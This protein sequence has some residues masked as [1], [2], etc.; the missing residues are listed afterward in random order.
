VS[1]PHATAAR[2]GGEG[3][4]PAATAGWQVR[5][6]VVALDASPASAAAARNA[7]R[8]AARLA[9]ELHGLFVEDAAILRLSGLPL[10]VEVGTFSAMPRRLAAGDVERRL[11]AQASRARR[12]LADSALAAAV[13]RYRFEVLR[14]EV[15]RAVA[16]AL[17][18]GDLL[19]LGRVGTTGL[20]RLGSVARAALGGG[21]GQLLLLPA[22]G[23]LEAPVVTVF[24][25][26]AGARRALAAALCLL[27]HE[28]PGAPRPGALTVLLV[29]ATDADAR[30]LEA[31][32][33]A[34]IA[35]AGHSPA[36]PRFRRARPG[37]RHALAHTVALDRANAL[38][39][40]ADSPL[41][42]PQDLEAVIE[43]LDCSVLLVR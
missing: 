12:L 43:G 26:A 25:D 38:L 41:V 28:P 6:I 33:R 18:E 29:A 40:P 34:T 4:P 37:D 16:G 10:C 21:R 36:L 14:G 19:S 2:S 24:G 7:A 31:E 42:R 30:R 17:G 8:L 5:R 11:H 9:A 13:E 35:A 23:R 22:E 39:L 32:A 15:G 1:D 27:D 3:P 20:A